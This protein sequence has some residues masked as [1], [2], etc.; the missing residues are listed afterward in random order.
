[1]KPICF[2]FS[3]SSYVL[4]FDETRMPLTPEDER[5]AR[6]R[7]SDAKYREAHRAERRAKDRAYRKRKSQDPAWM[8]MRR[9][10]KRH[11]PADPAWTEHER[12]RKRESRRRLALDPAWRERQRERKRA[13]YA[14]KSADPRMLLDGRVDSRGKCRFIPSHPAGPRTVFCAKPVQYPGA[15]YCSDCMK[16]VYVVPP[17]AAM[18]ARFAA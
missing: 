10:Q 17:P 6:K 15:S 11:D 4:T 18:E 9:Q 1:M 13:L 12:E 3:R 7:A 8:E 5:R 2:A 14:R 16:I